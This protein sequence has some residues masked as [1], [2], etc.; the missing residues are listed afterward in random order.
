M[1]IYL[2]PGKKRLVPDRNGELYV[3]KSMLVFRT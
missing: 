1:G 3:D 2:N